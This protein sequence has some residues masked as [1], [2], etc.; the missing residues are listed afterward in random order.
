MIFLLVIMDAIFV[1]LM[2]KVIEF[3]LLYILFSSRLFDIIR[4]NKNINKYAK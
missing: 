4:I 2:S 3:V 1:F